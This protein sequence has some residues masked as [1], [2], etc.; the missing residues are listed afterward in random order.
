M[1]RAGVHFDPT[2]RQLY[3]WAVAMEV[4]LC[5]YCYRPL[6]AE[7]KVDHA[8]YAFAVWYD[9]DGRRHS[10]APIAGVAPGAMDR[11]RVCV[12]CT[13]RHSLRPC[14]QCAALLPE[15][16]G[17]FLIDV[18]QGYHTAWSA[19]SG[20]AWRVFPQPAARFACPDCFT[21]HAALGRSTRNLRFPYRPG[22]SD[23]S[24]SGPLCNGWTVTLAD[25]A[26]AHVHGWVHTPTSGGWSDTNATSLIRREE[27]QWS[28]CLR[29]C[30]S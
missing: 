19:P 17:Y 14:E 2:V 3:E 9:P 18:T 20:P 23:A 13:D 11:L 30:P 22:S 6:S 10:L 5:V 29:P 24:S 1:P 26:G 28:A 15:R 21:T 4:T 25:N 8:P 27:A 12:E 7:R 16:F